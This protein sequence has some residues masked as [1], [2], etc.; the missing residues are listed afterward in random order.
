M[1][2]TG[3]NFHSLDTKNRIFIPASFREE[4]GEKFYAYR[5][6]DGCIILYN[7]ER[8]SQLAEKAKEKNDEDGNRRYKRSFMSKVCEISM[9][10]QGRVTLNEQLLQHAS[11]K[12][13]VVILG[14]YDCIEIWDL[15]VWNKMQE[16]E[17][18]YDFIL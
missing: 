4:L 13:D 17:E 2:F 5:S 9:D 7:N 6:P 8:W 18:D 3:T 12:K 11:L 14:M 10:K 15:D 16:E 1:G